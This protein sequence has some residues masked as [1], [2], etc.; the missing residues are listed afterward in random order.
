MTIISP[1]DALRIFELTILTVALW[2]RV[3]LTKS[4]PSIYVLTSLSCFFI[5]FKDEIKD[6]LLVKFLLALIKPCESYKATLNIEEDEAP[7][8]SLRSI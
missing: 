1:I 7:K 5:K 6:E 4:R 2:S 8:E 3:T